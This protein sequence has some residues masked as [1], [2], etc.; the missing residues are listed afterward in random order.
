MKKLISMILAMAMVVTSINFTPKNVSAENDG[1]GWTT[2]SNMSYQSSNTP[3]T[4]NYKVAKGAESSAI[5][6]Y[7]HHYL[8]VYPEGLTGADNAKIYLNE[9]QTTTG[10]T[11]FPGMKDHDNTRYNIGLG[12]TVQCIWG[13]ALWETGYWLMVKT[14]MLP[15]MCCSPPEHCGVCSFLD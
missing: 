14:G 4:L 5:E 3:M 7:G 10:E 9:G 11:V 8:H 2:I 1:S 13:I 6:A 15:L 12:L